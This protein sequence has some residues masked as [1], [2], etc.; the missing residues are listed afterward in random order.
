MTPLSLAAMFANIQWNPLA[1]LGFGPTPV[2]RLLCEMCPT[3]SQIRGQSGVL[4]P[5]SKDNAK[6][7]W[8]ACDLI[9][10]WFSSLGSPLAFVL[11]PFPLERQIE[12]KSES[13][14][15]VAV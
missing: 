10:L 7:L 9:T 1:R 4:P 5:H 12:I 14:S 2:R 3:G 8:N 6:S 11:I 13:K 15:K